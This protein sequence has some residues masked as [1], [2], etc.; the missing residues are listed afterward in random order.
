M[1]Q[2]AQSVNGIAL[3][4]VPLFSEL[5]AEELRS[6]GARAQR[7]RF[8]AGEAVF[9]KD[10]PGSMLY[11]MVSGLVKITL[12]S[13][14]GHE[15]VLAL[16]SAGEVFGELALLDGQ[17]RSASAVAMDPTETLTLRRDDF[18]AFVR[19]N[20]DAA[21]KIMGI[22]SSRLRNS[23]DLIA[24]TMFLDVPTRIAKK[25][26]DL[27]ADFGKRTDL[28]VEIELR[29]RQQDMASM[30]GASRESVNRCLIMLEDRGII[31]LDKQRITVLR[32]EALAA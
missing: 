28:G 19:D 17:P 20:P 8:R 23:N 32:P 21:I 27:A 26:V 18:L 7:R 10:D 22:L 30:V 5:S 6:L 1:T 29:L 13:D 11:V 31:K 9:H 12:P 16:V 14:E 25:L 15:A 24:D 4:R 2:D 3:R